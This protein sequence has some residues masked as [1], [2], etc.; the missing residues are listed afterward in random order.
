ML[1]SYDEFYLFSIGQSLA[2]D[3]PPEYL[4]DGITAFRQLIFDKIAALSPAEC[5]NENE[6][7]VVANYCISTTV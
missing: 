4:A 5:V 3:L 1:S 6:T 2:K 7:L